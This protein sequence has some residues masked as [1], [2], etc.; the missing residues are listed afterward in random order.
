[1]APP[2]IQAQET[3]DVPGIELTTFRWNKTTLQALIVT[4]ENQTW[5]KP[6]FVDISQRA[7]DQWNQASEFFAEKYPDY[8]YVSSINI[9][10][11]LSNTTLPDYDIYIAF[12]ETLAIQNQETLGLTTTFP[13]RDGSIK[14]AT[15]ELSSKSGPID[16]TSSDQRD[17]ATHEFGHALGLGHS[18]SSKDLMYPYYD[19]FSS[20]N[21]ISTLDL[22]GLATTFSWVTATNDSKST[23]NFTTLPSDITY[24]YAPVT[25]PT[26]KGIE[27]NPLVKAVVIFLATPYMAIMVVAL[28]FFLVVSVLAVWGSR[29][30]SRRPRN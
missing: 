4:Q 20:D 16:L 25:S 13:N 5:W 9:I 1:M 28:I 18:N 24:E 8:A 29:R 7:V 12:A 19:L 22:Y 23:P 11:R 21:A 17:V 27:D 3:Q 6:Y 10:L 14:N 30:R 2:I 26:P 15:I